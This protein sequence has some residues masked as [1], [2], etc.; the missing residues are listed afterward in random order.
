[1]SR[2][3]ELMPWSVLFRWRLDVCRH[4]CVSSRLPW[5]PKHGEWRCLGSQLFLGK[6]PQ[7]FQ[8]LVHVGNFSRCM[9]VNSANS[10]VCQARWTGKMKVNTVDISAIVRRHIWEHKLTNVWKETS[11]I[12][13]EHWCSKQYFVYS[14]NYMDESEFRLVEFAKKIV[15]TVSTLR[16]VYWYQI[17][18]HITYLLQI[19]RL[20]NTSN[21][22]YSH[23]RTHSHTNARTHARVFRFA[24][25]RRRNITS[26]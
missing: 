8:I 1:M 10:L 24:N 5:Q 4:C 6:T 20:S 16:A 25:V 15:Y 11:E 17:I 3:H 12:P 19:C 26:E 22:L 21:L 14:Y 13:M 2:S 23:T 18:T 7:S 9:A